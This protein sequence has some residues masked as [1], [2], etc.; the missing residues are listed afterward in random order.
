MDPTKEIK[1]NMFA[2]GWAQKWGHHWQRKY[3]KPR[4]TR[5]HVKM[6]LH[7][8]PTI[9]TSFVIPF[10]MPREFW[11][12]SCIFELMSVIKKHNLLWV[13]NSCLF[14]F[15]N[16][17]IILLKKKLNCCWLLLYT[18][19][20]ETNIVWGIWMSQMDPRSKTE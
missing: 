12:N 15:V 7:S 5:W 1:E 4:Q 17:V 3:L 2:R 19:S 14:A 9:I 6:W 10:V 11:S 8:Y 20:L 13:P 18:T 16:L